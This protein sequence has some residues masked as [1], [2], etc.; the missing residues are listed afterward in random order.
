MKSSNFHRIFCDTELNVLLSVQGV[1]VKGMLC[2]V[3]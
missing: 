1:C 3:D 2:V